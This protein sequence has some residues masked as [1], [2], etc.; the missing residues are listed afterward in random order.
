[1]IAQRNSDEFIRNYKN[2]TRVMCAWLL[3]IL[4]CQIAI[5]DNKDCVRVCEFEKHDFEFYTKV[6]LFDDDNIERLLAFYHELRRN[7]E[8]LMFIEIKIIDFILDK[9]EQ[10]KHI[11]KYR[12]ELFEIQ[13]RDCQILIVSVIKD[14]D[15]VVFISIYYFR[16]KNSLIDD[17]I[18]FENQI[19]L[20]WILHSFAT[21]SFELIFFIISRSKIEETL[22]QIKKYLKEIETRW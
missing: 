17:Q 4:I 19:K 9:H 13:I 6:K 3:K 20:S 11:V 16:R 22:A 15:F 10:I 5:K 2:H 1:M 8:N 18:C 12:F 7:D 14:S 21:F